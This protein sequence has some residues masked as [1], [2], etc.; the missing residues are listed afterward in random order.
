MRDDTTTPD[1]RLSDDPMRLN[2]ASVSSLI[3][4]TT[5]G[6]HPGKVGSILHC[7]LRYFDPA[8]RRAGLPEDVGALVEKLG[9]DDVTVTLVNVN[10]LEER[11]LVVQ[12]GGYGEHRF[13]GVTANGE[14]HTLDGPTVTVRLEPGAGT[15]FVLS[16]KR[17]VNVPTMAFP[18]DRETAK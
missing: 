14:K 6:L 9:P 3:E 17:Y 5:G 13:T 18:W 10:Q 16:M 4:Q 15:R 7:R 11:T 1:T 8:A 2:P 12:A